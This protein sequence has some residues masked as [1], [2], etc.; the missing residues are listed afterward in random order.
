MTF[1][2]RPVGIVRTT[3]AALLAAMSLSTSP[4]AFAECDNKDCNR[5]A[6]GLGRSIAAKPVAP[7]PLPIIKQPWAIAQSASEMTIII[8]P[9][10]NVFTG[11][12]RAGADRPVFRLNLQ[13]IN[14]QTGKPLEAAPGK[15]LPKLQARHYSVAL[16]GTNGEFATVVDNHGNVYS[17]AIRPPVDIAPLL[18]AVRLVGGR[19]C[20]KVDCE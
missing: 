14:M 13:R 17:G 1:P 10:G 4:L 15:P 3:L 2:S 6:T 5:T 20:D 11:T 12:S 8:D 19:T 9:H 7:K 16:A 18:Q